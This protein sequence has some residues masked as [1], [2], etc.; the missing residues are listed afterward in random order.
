VKGCF[1]INNN[2]LGSLKGG[3]LSPRSLMIWFVCSISESVFKIYGAKIAPSEANV[4]INL[5]E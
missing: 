2:Q 4:S 1:G 3:C 5:K